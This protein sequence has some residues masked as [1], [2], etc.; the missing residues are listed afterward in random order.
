MI[1][2]A[3]M[4]DRSRTLLTRQRV[5]LEA[6]EAE[7]FDQRVRLVACDRMAHGLAAHRRGLEAPGT[8]AR[9]DMKSGD[10]RLAHD[11]REVRR[12]VRHAGPL[13]VHLDVGERGE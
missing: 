6:I 1:F 9:I 7:A 11:R 2:M 4:P 3:S 13:P 10:G 12:H 5:A 8:P